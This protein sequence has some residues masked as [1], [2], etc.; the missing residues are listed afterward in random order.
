[1]SSEDVFEDW[2][3]MRAE[4]ARLLERFRA[5]GASADEAAHADGF[6]SWMGRV[7]E[8]R[9][10]ERDVIEFLWGFVPRKVLGTEDVL[11]EV[12]AAVARLLE[13]LRSDPGLDTG[14]ALGV[15]RDRSTFLRR[16]RSFEGSG[17][18]WFEELGDY[19]GITG[20]EPF[21]VLPDGFTW[22]GIQGW[23][24][25]RAFNELRDVLVKAV[26]DGR[27]DPDAPGWRARSAVIQ[28]TWL[29]TP[30][31]MF[32]GRSPRAVIA[33]ERAHAAPTFGQTLEGVKSLQKAG[34]FRGIPFDEIDGEPAPT[35]GRALDVGESGP[36]VFPLRKLPTESELVTAA[37]GSRLLDDVRALL[38]RIGTGSR[39]TQKGNLNLADA[40]ALAVAIGVGEM[41]DPEIGGQLFHTKSSTEIPTVHL[42]FRAARAAGFVR[43]QHGKVLPTKR[44][45][46]LGRDPL[47]DWGDLFEAVVW[48][49]RWPVHAYPD[50]RTAFWA[51]DLADLM[52]RLLEGLY[53]APPEESLPVH[54]LSALLW[55]EFE[56]IYDLDGL[57]PGQREYLP[58]R[59]MWNVTQAVFEPL[60]R[61]GAVELRIP[62]EPERPSSWTD[63]EATR[64]YFLAHRQRE[65]G[66]VVR[67]T[68]L[69]AWAARAV[70]ARLSG[71]TEP[72][73]AGDLGA[74][75][76]SA[77]ALVALAQEHELTPDEVRAEAAAF[78]E[79]AGASAAEEFARMLA[80]GGPTTLLVK[81][82][83][84]ALP[85]SELEP[86]VRSAALTASSGAG[87][88][89][90][91][92]WLTEHGL[93]APPIAP[94]HDELVEA[95]IWSVVEVARADGPQGTAEMLVVLPES[96]Q[97]EVAESVGSSA[98]PYALEAAMAIAAAPLSS[99]VRKAG[100]RSIHRLRT[101]GT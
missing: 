26:A 67:L 44:A 93:D 54:R 35:G 30:S 88:M 4:H 78:R 39:L 22:G 50:D 87:A 53:A 1:M 10:N 96:E 97:L 46:M 12:R 38:E 27:V 56:R 33:N 58:G 77:E 55:E 69:G 86:A 31:P 100:R 15:A 59:L 71:G 75:A 28:L 37:A 73:A 21:Q 11:D 8:L 62:P 20:M 49:L 60:D 51:D 82:C 76:R 64:A 13:F 80:A 90:C 95:T 45:S 70:I 3:R 25:A 63:D 92:A 83:M 98:S 7:T 74:R 94:S 34:L 40:R 85:D 79:Q 24:E 41:F 29:D 52:P 19:L 91:V 18:E 89:Q 2:D 61:L 84:D 68:P 57:T 99:A 72:P 47:A 65:R 81:A 66:I 16:V 32:D 23:N 17:S 43:V 101:R 6:L 36:P 5:W 42:A 14:A 48:K 9:P